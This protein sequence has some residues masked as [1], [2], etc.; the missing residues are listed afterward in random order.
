ALIY[1]ARDASELPAVGDWVAAHAIAEDEAMIHSV[2]PR[3]TSFSRRAAGQRDQEQIIAAN[4]DLALIVCGLDGDF[5][6]RR[7]ERYLTLAREGGVD[8]AI[9]LNKNDLCADPQARVEEVRRIAGGAP[10]LSICA[11]SHEA[12]RSSL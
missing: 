4:I 12:V 5:N 2:L 7:I 9:I 11:P 10:G 3:R 6:L 8:A 1:R